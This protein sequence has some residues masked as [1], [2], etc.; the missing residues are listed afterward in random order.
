MDIPDNKVVTHYNFD[1]IQT[2]NRPTSL[3]DRGNNLGRGGRLGWSG[4]PFLL[5][6]IARVERGLSKAEE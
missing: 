4:H 3:L 1:L 2:D 6:D 5:A